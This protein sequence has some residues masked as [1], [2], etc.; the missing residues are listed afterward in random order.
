ML[1]KTPA[2]WF[3]QAYTAQGLA[4]ARLQDMTFAKASFDRAIQLDPEDFDALLNRGK[5]LTIT[6][7]WL[8]ASQDLKRA[9]SLNP[10]SGAV[11]QALGTLA[12]YQGDLS[13]ALEEY[14]RARQAKGFGCLYSCE[15]RAALRTA[16]PTAES[17]SRI[18]KESE[19]RSYQSRGD[20]RLAKDT[21]RA[22]R[23]GGIST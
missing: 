14:Q 21:V 23:T 12:F 3:S 5:L 6:S 20:R 22:N 7:R 8:D 19:V 1:P 9:V 18:S 10:D 4:A 11:H 2:R 17:A 15:S 16:R 13:R